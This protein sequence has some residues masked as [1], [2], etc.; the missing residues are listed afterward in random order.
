MQDK[1]IIKFKS[2]NQKENEKEL[3]K[4]F[5]EQN[6]S[7]FHSNPILQKML[8]SNTIAKKIKFSLKDILK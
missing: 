3:T 7:C 2:V 8:L 6:K 1:K 5:P 4:K